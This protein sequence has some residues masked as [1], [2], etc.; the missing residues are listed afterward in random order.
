ME[1]MRT[2]PSVPPSPAT[3]VPSSA[4]TGASPETG[5]V[6]VSSTAPT[7]AQMKTQL[8]AARAT[9]AAWLDLVV[10]SIAQAEWDA[11]PQ[12]ISAPVTGTTTV[13]TEVTR[14]LPC[15]VRRTR[16]PRGRRSA[17]AEL[18]ACTLGRTQFV[19]AASSVSTKAMKA[20]KP[21]QTS[22]AQRRSPRSA[23]RARGGA[24]EGTS[25]AMGGPTAWTAQMNRLPRV[26]TTTA[27]SARAA[28]AAPAESAAW[29][30]LRSVTA[31]REMGSHFALTDPTR[32]PPFAP[33]NGRATSLAN[34]DAETA[35]ASMENFATGGSI[36]QTVRTRIPPTARPP[37][38]R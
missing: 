12:I 34:S 25:S 3:R 31:S 8:F 33:G 10:T 21:A 13:W 37:R 17:P 28:H 4:A 24:S 7:A 36:V 27:R 20:Q 32:T 6:T 5:F 11:F 35:R 15:A 16:V 30:T 29:T 2:Q 26:Q 18:V 14:I 19:T 38:V 23:P 9:I 1:A 22:R